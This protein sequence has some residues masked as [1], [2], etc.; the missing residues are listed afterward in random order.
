M[1]LSKIYSLTWNLPAVCILALDRTLR[2]VLILDKAGRSREE[3]QGF[4]L[5]QETGPDV[6]ILRVDT[7]QRSRNLTAGHPHFGLLNW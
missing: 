2:A 4:V 1:L 7:P 6:L 3:R 5:K